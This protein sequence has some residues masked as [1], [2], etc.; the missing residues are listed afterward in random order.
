M[1]VA[2]LA[3]LA[4]CLGVQGCVPPPGDY[5]GAPPGYAPQPYAATPG[6]V[7]QQP[8]PPP[9]QD[10]SYAPPGYAQP[11]YAQPGYPP[12]GYAEPPYL[13]PSYPVP[14]PAYG[15]AVPP[16][17]GFYGGRP[18]FD[19]DRFERGPDFRGPNF[20]PD[21]RGPDF[22]GP[23]F[24]GPDRE[25]F[26]RERFERSRFRERVEQNRPRPPPPG[27]ALQGPARPQDFRRPL[28]R[29]GFTP[30]QMRQLR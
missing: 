8:L 23:D 17:F 1:R 2:W 13:Q 22:R 15:Y 11:G 3:G 9:D 30:E 28:D 5:Y 19:R 12:V 29:P 10:G 7:V 25:R 26:E 27:Q 24:R 18:R 21:F 14:Q 6:A 16:P 20:R 4:A